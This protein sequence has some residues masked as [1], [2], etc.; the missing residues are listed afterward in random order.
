MV[1]ACRKESDAA[2]YRPGHRFGNRMLTEFVAHVFGRAFSDILSGYRVF[3]RR[4]V[5]SFPAIATGFEIE[6]ELTI[7]ALELRMPI[8]EVETPYFS[9]QED[10]ES[11]LHTYRDGLRILSTIARLYQLQRPLAFFSALAALLAA[12]AVLLAVPILVTYMQT[13]L[14]P[15]LPTA[16]LSTGL[17]ILACLALTCGLI[18][19]NVTRGRQEMKRLLYLATQGTRRDPI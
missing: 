19:D 5:K 12:V 9:R 18:L 4:F 10:S 6:T 16:I 1:V 15:R 7:H 17:M 14:V 3:S 8:G 11:K 2:A 13:G